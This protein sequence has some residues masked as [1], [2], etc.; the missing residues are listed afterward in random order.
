MSRYGL[1]VTLCG[2][3]RNEPCTSWRFFRDELNITYT[4]TSTKP[5]SSVR[6]TRRVH[7]KDFGCAIGEGRSVD[8]DIVLAPSPGR[9]QQVHGR[10]HEQEEQQQDGHRRTRAEVPVDERGLVDVD[11][12]QVRVV[13]RVLP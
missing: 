8:L 1:T 4:G 11:R 10:H 7:R 2:I 3:H 12:Y 13:R 6:T 9:D 5:S